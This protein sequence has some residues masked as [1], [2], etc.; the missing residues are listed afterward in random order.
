[1]DAEKDPQLQR[2]I[3]WHL[4]RKQEDFE[5]EEFSIF[6]FSVPSALARSALADYYPTT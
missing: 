2:R 4:R 3:D 5:K 6:A 1:M